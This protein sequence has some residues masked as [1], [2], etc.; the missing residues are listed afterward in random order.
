MLIAHL[1]GLL[2]PT[3]ASGAQSIASETLIIDA[4]ELEKSVQLRTDFKQMESTLLAPFLDP[5]KIKQTLVDASRDFD[6]LAKVSML[7]LSTQASSQAKGSIEEITEL[8]YA[9]GKAGLV[10][11]APE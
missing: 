11:M 3:Y 4:I 2:K 1:R 5:K 6:R 10:T 9:L 8:Y 7:D